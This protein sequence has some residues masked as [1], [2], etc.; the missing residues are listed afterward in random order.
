MNWAGYA[1]G[2]VTPWTNLDNWFGISIGA[3]ATL[4]AEHFWLRCIETGS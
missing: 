4:L 1:F 2:Q 3:A